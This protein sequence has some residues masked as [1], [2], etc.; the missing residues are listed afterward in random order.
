MANRTEQNRGEQIGEDQKKA[1][2]DNVTPMDMNMMVN[3]VAKFKSNPVVVFDVH[4]S[5]SAGTGSN[6]SSFNHLAHTRPAA[7]TQ[8]SSSY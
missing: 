2:C 4:P 6:I 7:V 1:A 5:K 8:S 3:C